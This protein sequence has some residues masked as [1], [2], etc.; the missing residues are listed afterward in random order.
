MFSVQGSR[1]ILPSS[2]I[3]TSLDDEH[4]AQVASAC[5][6]LN[7]SG[8]PTVVEEDVAFRPW[9]AEPSMVAKVSKVTFG[10]TAP[11]KIRV[12]QTRQVDER[13]PHWDLVKMPSNADFCG[14]DRL[15]HVL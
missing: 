8:Y 10:N 12:F 13:H 5:Q 15:E 14:Q 3:C 4:V 9:Q 2:F 7:L 1:I 11:Q 6:R